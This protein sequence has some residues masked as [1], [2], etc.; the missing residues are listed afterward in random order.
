MSSSGGSKLRRRI[1]RFVGSAIA[2][3]LAVVLGSA[4]WIAYAS[5]GRVHDAADSPVA[6]VV[7]VL[8]SQV[9]DGKPMKYLSGR[10]DA[11]IAVLESGRAKA[12]L[13]SGDANGKSGNEIAAMTNYL[14]DA[15]IDPAK[16]VGD[17]YG[18]DT[19]DTC[20]RAATTFGVSKALVVSQGLH[21]SRAVA[22]CRDAGV[23]AQGVDAECECN[24]LAVARNYGREW[25]ARPKAILDLW[26]GREPAV[27][28]PPDDSLTTASVS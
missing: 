20:H 2:V 16:I 24:W 26:S 1:F 12:V 10:L 11:A 8:G 6:P 3:V 22:L 5:F 27:V 19:Y 14:V 17:D 18:L 9:R 25:L 23:D 7:I 15:G 28:T 13:V 21:V 4:G